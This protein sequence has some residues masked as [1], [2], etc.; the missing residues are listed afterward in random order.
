MK[1]K[2]RK[3][4][5]TGGSGFIGTNVMNYLIENNFSCI[6]IDF[7][8][9]KKRAHM[10][11]WID[12]DILDFDALE[13]AITSF[14]PTHIIH[15]AATLGMDHKTLETLDTNITGTKNL[16]KI[17]ESK[18]DIKRI[19]FTSSL[20]VCRGGYIPKNDVDYCPPNFYGESKAIGEKLV[21]SAKL[22]CEWVIVRPTSIWGPWFDYSY[23]S[24]FKVIDKNMYMH[25]GNNEIQKPASFSGNTVYMLMKILF[26]NDPKINKNTYYLADYPWYSSK[27]WANTIQKTLDSKPIRTAPLWLLRIIAIIGSLI[28]AIFR[29]DPPLTLSRLNNMHIGGI[30]PIDNTKNVSGTLPHDLNESVYLTAKWMY[31]NNLIKHKPRKSD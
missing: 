30:Y 7:N 23:K 25:I 28:K 9:P 22:K 17:L 4:L 2:K 13:N 18:N 1:N 8:P 3:L 21:R 14:G 5:I 19:I 6:N 31:E 24:F 16:I 20:L 11:Y 27:V 15:L 12:V 10:G 29:I 26:E